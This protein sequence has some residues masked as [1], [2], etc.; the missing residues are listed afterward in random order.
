MPQTIVCRQLGFQRAETE[1]KLAAFG[2]GQGKT[3]MNNV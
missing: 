1:A 3:L 2:E